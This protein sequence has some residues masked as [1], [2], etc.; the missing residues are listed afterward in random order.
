M[1]TLYCALKFNIKHL[2]VKKIQPYGH[3]NDI[4][5]SASNNNKFTALSLAQMTG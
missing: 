2:L 5:I 1:N 4:K 3:K